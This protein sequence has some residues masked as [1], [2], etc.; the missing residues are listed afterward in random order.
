MKLK[1]NKSREILNKS[2]ENFFLNQFLIALLSVLILTILILFGFYFFINPQI[3]K[4]ESF[5]TSCGDGT[6]F[7]KCSSNKPYFCDKGLLIERA[8]V[9][10]CLE[11]F[12]ILDDKCLS[13]LYDNYTDIN[14]SYVLKGKNGQISFRV[15]KGVYDYL[16][17]LPY[18]IN[19]SLDKNITRL[20]FKMKK[21]DDE[22]QREAILP[23]VISIQNLAPNDK[24]DQARIA[25]SLV[26]NIHYNEF[27]NVNLINLSEKNSF[28]KYPYQVIYDY[29]GSCEGKSELLVFLLKEL[30]YD[31]AFFYYP[32]ENHEAVGIRCPNKYSLNN[33]GY[34]FVETTS[35][36]ILGDNQGEYIGQYSLKSNPKLIIVSKGI[37]LPF[38]MQE[39]EDSAFFMKIREKGKINIFN[40]EKYEQ[41]KNWYGIN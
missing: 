7:N 28:S 19:S 39:Y 4:V 27:N 12:S 3:I 5:K 8:S 17:R 37:S 18:S 14:L 22:I 15:Y 2:S 38:E 23:L 13:S 6:L 9:C 1:K 34:C 10:G 26:Q 36:S 33:S 11:G 41:I 21:I 31:V 32:L 24:K 29:A 16:L 30:G 35:P 25:I 40:K 20:N